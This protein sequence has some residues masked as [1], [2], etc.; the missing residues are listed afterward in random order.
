MQAFC[1]CLLVDLA[2]LFLVIAWAM[3]IYLANKLY[4]QSNYLMK[5]KEKDVAKYISAKM[6]LINSPLHKFE[7]KFKINAVHSLLNNLCRFIQRLPQ[8]L[9]VLGLSR[10]SALSGVAT[11]LDL[12]RWTPE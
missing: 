8:Y 5:I 9:C 11:H 6:Y 1:I 10:V 12:Q 7:T 4:N 3:A 2:F